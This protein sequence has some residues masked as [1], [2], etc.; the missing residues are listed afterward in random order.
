MG[1]GYYIEKVSP[2]GDRLFW[3][4]EVRGGP[5]M[6]ANEGRAK[7]IGLREWAEDELDALEQADPSLQITEIVS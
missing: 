6:T 5:V 4:G 7:R 1:M 2:S 3:T